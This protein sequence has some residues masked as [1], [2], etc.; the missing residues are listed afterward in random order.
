MAN[1]I[2]NWITPPG[3][4]RTSGAEVIRCLVAA[5]AVGGVDDV[6]FTVSVNGGAGSDTVVTARDIWIPDFSDFDDPVTGDLQAA[7]LA[8]GFELDMGALANGTIDVTPV[9]TPTTGSPVTI[10]RK[11]VV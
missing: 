2:C 9:V 3:I 1:P 6:T 10:D 5:R 4:R 7:V 11:S 8:Y